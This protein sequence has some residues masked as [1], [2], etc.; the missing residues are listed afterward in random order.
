MYSETRGFAE[1]N[2]FQKWGNMKAGESL[3]KVKV[4]Q[5][6]STCIKLDCGNIAI[7]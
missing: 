6:C 5:V 4:A 2:K 3:L 1:K 7:I